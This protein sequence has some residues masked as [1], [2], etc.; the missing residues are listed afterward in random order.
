MFVFLI[1]TRLRQISLLVVGRSIQEEG[2]VPLLK[3]V[4]PVPAAV[5]LELSRKQEA[6][7]L[8]HRILVNLF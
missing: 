8:K 7:L 4:Q 5:E 1:V 6:I 2:H 3:R